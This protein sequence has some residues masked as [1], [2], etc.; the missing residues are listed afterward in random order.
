MK[1]KPFNRFCDMFTPTCLKHWLKGNT[2]SSHR[3]HGRAVFPA[4]ARLIPSNKAGI[5]VQAGGHWLN[6]SCPW[7][8]GSLNHTEWKEQSAQKAPVSNQLKLDGIIGT[9]SAFV[10]DTRITTLTSPESFTGCCTSKRFCNFW[11][12]PVLRWPTWDYERM[13]WNHSVNHS[14]SLNQNTF[15]SSST[16]R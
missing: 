16:G 10:R 3:W 14:L 6:I 2:D 8:T 12:F 5:S 4:E 9:N 11:G 15:R 13:Y 1:C 7:E